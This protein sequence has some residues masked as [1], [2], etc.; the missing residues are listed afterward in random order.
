MGLQLQCTRQPR[1]ADK[2][3]VN[4]DSPCGLPASPPSAGDGESADHDG[5]ADADVAGC[6]GGQGLGGAAREVRQDGST[7]DDADVWGRKPEQAC[8]EWTCRD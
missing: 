4:V 1:Q 5:A 2:P 7:H 3:A 6:S 8:A